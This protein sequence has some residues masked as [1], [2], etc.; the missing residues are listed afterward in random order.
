MTIFNRYPFKVDFRVVISTSKYGTYKKYWEEKRTQK[1][2]LLIWQLHLVDI[3]GNQGHTK[4]RIRTVGQ[5]NTFPQA[6][7]G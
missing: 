4:M 3:V 7:E 5:R 6:E 1:D 2:A